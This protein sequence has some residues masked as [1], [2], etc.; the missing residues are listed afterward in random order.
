MITRG[1]G[2]QLGARW[3]AR[4]AK[5]AHG[6]QCLTFAA[7]GGTGQPGHTVAQLAETEQPNGP[8]TLRLAHL[9]RDR[10]VSPGMMAVLA[11]VIGRAEE[12]GAST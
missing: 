3:D 8:E 11:R 12:R 9:V 4:A 1:A 6:H 10:T 5:A 2:P 7:F